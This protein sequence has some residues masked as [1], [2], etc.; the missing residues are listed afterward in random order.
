MARRYNASRTLRI[1]VCETDQELSETLKRVLLNNPLVAECDVANSIGAA[2]QILQFGHTNIV[3]LDF[4]GL[5]RYESS[6]LIFALR[7][8]SAGVVFVLLA[9]DTEFSDNS[10]FFFGERRRL[11]HYY[12]LAGRL[13]DS[14]LASAVHSIVVHCMMDLGMS[15]DIKP[16]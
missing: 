2:K 11:L 13:E 8:K 7:K 16:E 5:G 9:D 4:F 6:D 14:E 15:A 3:F 12:R 1:L 10:S